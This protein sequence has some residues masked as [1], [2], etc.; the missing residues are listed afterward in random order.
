[1]H[2]HLLL[3]V[4]ALLSAPVWPAAA[5]PPVAIEDTLAPSE[6]VSRDFPADFLTRLPLD[7][8]EQTASQT[9]WKDPHVGGWGGTL[10]GGASCAGWYRS[11]RS[12]HRPVV[13]V[14]GNTSDAEFWR[15][16]DSGDGTTENVRARFLAAGYAP[17]ELWAVSYDGSPGYFTY[18]DI[19][20]AEVYSFITGVKDYLGA[21]SAGRWPA[22]LPCWRRR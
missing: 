18:N 20:T 6:P 9:S 12:T 5:G 14:H 2:R 17:C 13:F 22:S 21:R 16:S 7:L 10:T 19:N 8:Q 15:G 3:V 11:H 1:V 4:L